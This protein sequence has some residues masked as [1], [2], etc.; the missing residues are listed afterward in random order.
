MLV[1]GFTDALSTLLAKQL[2]V[3]AP[4]ICRSSSRAAQQ[5]H[6]WKPDL[7]IMHH[8]AGT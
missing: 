4:K 6:P 2:S 7:L 5:C 8:Y 1:M 3:T